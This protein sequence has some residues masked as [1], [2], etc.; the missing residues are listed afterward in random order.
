M[1]RYEYIVPTSGVATEIEVRFIGLD[2]KEGTEGYTKQSDGTIKSND[3]YT[4][5][6]AFT[7][8]GNGGLRRTRRNMGSKI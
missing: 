5:H 8:E 6:P 1:P 4:I 7:N 3:G 2:K